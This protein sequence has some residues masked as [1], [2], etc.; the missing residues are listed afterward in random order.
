[1]RE[2][3]D[4]KKDLGRCDME[5]LDLLMRR[6]SYAAEI[7]KCKNNHRHTYQNMKR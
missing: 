3:N 4:I 2:L 1:M 7:M 6:L 5:I